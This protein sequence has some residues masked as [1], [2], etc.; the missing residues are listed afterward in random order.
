MTKNNPL[1]VDSTKF[2]GDRISTEIELNGVAVY[3]GECVVALV[4]DHQG[5]MVRAP[6]EAT[7]KGDFEAKIWLNH[8]KKVTCQFLIEQDGRELFHSSTFEARAQH[9]IVKKWEPVMEDKPVVF[10]RPVLNDTDPPAAASPEARSPAE[11]ASHAEQL[12]EKWDL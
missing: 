4:I 3:E 8:Q 5:D 7:S 9:A 12:I 6:M 1:F 2:H 11:W 10:D